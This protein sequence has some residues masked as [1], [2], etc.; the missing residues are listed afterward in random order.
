MEVGRGAGLGAGKPR[1]GSGFCLAMGPSASL[2]SSCA[3]VS[4]CKM[5]GTEQVTPMGPSSLETREDILESEDLM[6]TQMSLFLWQR[7]E[8]VQA[9]G[10]LQGR[11]FP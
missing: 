5:R 6:G 10:C 4:L 7:S 9:G 3:Q 11:E 2:V 1:F 8:N